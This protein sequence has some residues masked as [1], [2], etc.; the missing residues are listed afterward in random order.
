MKLTILFFSML[1]SWAAVN[2]QYFQRINA[3]VVNNGHTLLSPWTGGVSAPQWSKVDLNGDGKIDLYAFDRDGFIHIPFLNTGNAGQ[4]NYVFA[5]EYVPNFPPTSHFVLLRDYNQDGAMDFFTHAQKE[6]VIP[7]F[8]VYNGKLENNQLVFEKETFSHWGYDVISYKLNNGTYANLNVNL[9]DYPAI[10]DMDGDGDLDILVLNPD[11]GFKITYFRNY[12][13]EQGF[14]TDTLI[15]TKED[16][17]WGNL[18]LPI[19]TTQFN[20]SGSADTCAVQ[21]APNPSNDDR[22][23]GLHGASTLCT[24]DE[25][26]DGD[27]ELLYGDLNFPQ[28]MKAYNGGTPLNA[29]ATDQDVTF[30]N[31]NAP[32]H[33]P[34]FPGSFFLDFDNDGL[35]D[36][37]VAPNEYNTS[38]DVEVWFYKNIASNEF[39][40]FNLAKKNAM[41]DE[42]ID[43][44][45]GSHPVFF[46]Y[47]ADGLQDIVIGNFQKKTSTPDDNVVE[48]SLYLFENTGT[49]TEPAYELIDEDWLGFKQ[50]S[51]TGSPENDT[52]H[53]APT[54]GDLDQDEDLD[55]LVGE[56]GGYL[57][58]VENTAGPNAPATWGPIFPLWKN[59]R[60]GSYPTP[61]IYDLNKDGLADILA[62]EK[63]GNINFFPN[64]GTVGN[65]N[66]HDNPKEFPNNEFLGKIS[67]QVPNSTNGF[68]A[69]VI[70]DFQ[71]T[72]YLISGSVLGYLEMYEV[73]TSKLEVGDSFN[74]VDKK[75]ANIRT[76]TH[77][78]VSF[79]N[80]NG[81]EI[82]DAIIGNHRGGVGVF[83]SPFKIDGS[84][85]AVESINS[86]GFKLFPNPANDFLIIEP[87]PMYFGKSEYQIINAVGQIVQHGT[88]SMGENKIDINPLNNGFY[89]FFLNQGKNTGV[90]KIIIQK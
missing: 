18:A 43:V 67:T 10:D 46:D 38:P 61:F 12:A 50:Y 68:S 89:L 52:K 20:L 8:V 32:V 44:G 42:M 88:L 56:E 1:L 82:L 78:R 19:E 69:P 87:D 51:N 40:T 35:N 90:Q 13:L 85:D 47:N 83:S 59:I 72:I 58:F 15:F 70:L 84:V 30:P 3:P 45:T 31:Y 7:G 33:L 29:Y 14:T 65:P 79:A 4:S 73:D 11:S 36:L 77:S 60:I 37:L 5:P 6:E 74:L 64:I 26:N 75:F 71:D 27:K 22:G 39:P 76:G 54:F 16:D 28:L 55:L 62:G 21:F 34:D 2:A 86:L 17:C 23:G 81:D 41:V 66:F 57:F 48:A 63:G 53:Y 24:F 49:N 25:D 9:T 80:I